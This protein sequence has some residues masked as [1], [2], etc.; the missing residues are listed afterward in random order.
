[1]VSLS[2]QQHVQQINKGQFVVN[3]S[4]K[5]NAVGRIF[6]KIKHCETET[7]C[8]GQLLLDKY[9]GAGA[10]IYLKKVEGKQEELNGTTFSVQTL[11]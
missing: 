9:L 7:L 10:Y 4:W 6:K 11:I 1:M 3:L 8:F 5:E 2:V